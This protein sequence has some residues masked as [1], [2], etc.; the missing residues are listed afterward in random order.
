VVGR[1][2]ELE[3]LRAAARAARSGETASVLLVG[4]GG[5]G[6]TRLLGEL[7]TFARQTDVAVLSGRAPIVT[8]APFSVFTEALRSWLRG[9]D[10]RVH[11][12][13]DRGSGRRTRVAVVG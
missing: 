2:D 1:D 10:H 8:P 12:A 7:A 11:A 3:L 9:H 6:K 4:E 5:V 13:F